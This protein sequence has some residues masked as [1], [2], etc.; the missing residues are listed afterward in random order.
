MATPSNTTISIDGTKL[1]AFSTHVSLASVVDG[2]GMPSMGSLS[3]GMEFAAD[4]HDTLNVPFASVKKFFDLANMPTQAKIKDIKIE[5]WKDESHADALCTLS[6]KGWISSW[7]VAS[8]GGGNHVL[9]I[10]IHPA[11]DA[12]NYHE[13]QLGN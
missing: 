2:T 10:S 13:L 12:K 11:L 5:F 4:M 7:T 3:C 6:F 9:N 1:N 8:G